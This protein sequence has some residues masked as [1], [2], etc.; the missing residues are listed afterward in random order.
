MKTNTISI[1]LTL[2][3]FS[4]LALTGLVTSTMLSAPV[5]AEKADS[6]KKTKID[7][8][9][10]V[11][12]GKTGTKTLTGNVELTRGTLLIRAESAVETETKDDGGSVTLLGKN[13]SQVFFRQK[14]DGGTELWIEG[15]AD[16]VEYDKKTEV[17]RFIAKANV[18][19]LSESKVTQE[20]KGEF[21]SYDSINDI[22][23]ATNSASGKRVPGGGRVSITSEPKAVKTPVKQDK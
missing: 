15:S 1:S 17:V 19:Y 6:Q 12:D 11:Y 20:Q 21:L 5:Y 10:T 2:S 23:T 18:R 4:K 3:I 9:H 16:R 7:A 13:G 22:F 8:E 14:R